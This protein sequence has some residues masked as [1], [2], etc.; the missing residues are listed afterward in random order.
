MSMDPI[1]QEAVRKCMAA[2]AN[3]DEVARIEECS[4]RATQF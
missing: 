1:Q 4:T 2:L 3:M